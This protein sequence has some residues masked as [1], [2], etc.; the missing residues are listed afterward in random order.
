MIS[1]DMV[2]RLIGLWR[3]LRRFHSRWRWKPRDAEGA[4][5]VAG[6]QGMRARRAGQLGHP[7]PDRS[8]GHCRRRKA[9]SSRMRYDP[10]AAG[11]ATRWLPFGAPRPWVA[12]IV[13]SLA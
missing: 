6:F 9:S 12:R 4:P 13:N 11:T 10:P 8:L 3:W 2:G 7:S 5:L 1:S